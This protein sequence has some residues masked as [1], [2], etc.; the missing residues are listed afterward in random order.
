MASGGTSQDGG[1]STRALRAPDGE[2]IAARRR[3]R[4]LEPRG[5]ARKGV[6]ALR[7]ASKVGQRQPCSGGGSVVE[8]SDGRAWVVESSERHVLGRRLGGEP[9]RRLEAHAAVALLWSAGGL[10]C[11]SARAPRAAA[12][13]S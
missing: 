13:Q 12:G 3:L 9:G 5:G 4:H 7:R 11:A 6:L 2:H 10:P 1:V 8:H